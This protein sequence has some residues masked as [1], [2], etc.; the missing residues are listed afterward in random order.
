VGSAIGSF[1]DCENFSWLSSDVG[2]PPTNI[3]AAVSSSVNIELQLNPSL[4][5][6]AL[7]RLGS[8]T[9]LRG[10]SHRTTRPEEIVVELHPNP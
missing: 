4:A 2:L 1:A 3:Q 7:L 6:N 8:A 9:R 10:R 5:K